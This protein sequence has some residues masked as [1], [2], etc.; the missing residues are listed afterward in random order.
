[1]VV[2]LA[3]EV[4]LEGVGG[5]AE[6]VRLRLGAEGAVVLLPAAHVAPRATAGLVQR[7]RVARDLVPPLRVDVDHGGAAV[8]RGAEEAALAVGAVGVE[9][10][11]GAGPAGG[12]VLARHGVHVLN[13][14]GAPAVPL[15]DERARRGRR[16]SGRRRRPRAARRD[17]EPVVARLAPGVGGDDD[18][19]RPA[20]LRLDAEVGPPLR[21]LEVVVVLLRPRGGGQDEV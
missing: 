9:D 6:G 11:E 15:P 12:R 8:G 3:V 18:A 19:P 21:A 1:H 7:E 2:V 10:E 17:G 14:T 4:A 16:R 13:D 5:E 20:L